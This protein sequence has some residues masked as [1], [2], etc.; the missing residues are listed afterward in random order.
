VATVAEAFAFALQHHQAGNLR[1][2]EQL[3]QQ[4]LCADPAHADSH[5]LLGVLAY[6]AG[7]FDLAVMRIR[8]ALTLNPAAAPYL[9]NLGVAQEALGQHEEA[10]ASFQEVLRLHPNS[11]EAHQGVGNALRVL[12]RLEQAATHYAQAV[13]LRP[14]FLE[15][16]SNL[17]N[18]LFLLERFEEAI[19]YYQKTLAL[20]SDWAEMHCNLSNALCRLGRWEQAV[21]HSR[22]ALRL[23]PNYP[24]AHNNLGNALRGL[25][26][27]EESVTHCRQA[28]Q[29]TPDMCEAHVNLGNALALLGRSD[30]A[31]A[32]FREALRLNANFA[33]AW[34]NLGNVLA[35]EGRFDEAADC[36]ERAIAI[37]PSF[38]HAYAN[39]G[40]VRFQQSRFAEAQSCYFEALQRNPHHAE[41]HFNLAL[42]WLLQGQWNKGW[43]EYEWRWQTADLPRYRFSQPRWD[44]SPARKSG[45]TLLLLAEQGLGDAIQFLRFL[46]VV[47]QLGWRV[48]LQCQ[49][50]LQRLL[51]TVPGIDLLLPQGNPVPAFDTY[52][53]L[54]T[55]PRVFGVS[56]T[57][58]PA[59][60]PY[61]HAEAKLIA[62]WRPRMSEVRCPV[63]DVK[64]YPFSDTGLRTPDSGRFLKIGISWQGNPTFRGDRQRSTPLAQF[65]PLAKVDGVRLIS[66]Q[67]GPGVDQLIDRHFPVLDLGNGL[68]EKSGAFMDTAAVIHNL[69]LVICSDTATAHLAGALGIPV[70]LA[71]SVVPDWRWQLDREDSAWY[72]SMRL[73]RQSR[74]GQWSDVFEKMA[75]QLTSSSGSL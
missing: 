13:R 43:E 73:F 53:P 27:L 21:A 60:V 64:K 45:G 32:T 51:S 28:V 46:P 8:H 57:T 56:P 10:L 40:F 65:A 61:L 16:L 41:T 59:P 50:P 3:Y 24:G 55:L 72:P 11:A 48:I 71:L 37:K 66:L 7:N 15:A 33:E 74:P 52:L 30:E 17:A 70:W 6:Q 42:L 34:S 12:G 36:H 63:S 58:I 2:A 49:P 54:L 5:H 26:M 25:G 39:L 35:L 1:Q 69:D 31:L 62:H 19:E 29:L 9:A 75:E 67:K 44:G 23:E 14:A 4:I 18:A 22:Q 20:K 68:D 47:R 38:P